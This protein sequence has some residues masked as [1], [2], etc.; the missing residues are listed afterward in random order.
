MQVTT[1]RAVLD[2]LTLSLGLFLIIFF[3]ILPSSFFH[4][5]F[6]AADFN[7]AK[8]ITA[9]RSISGANFFLFITYLANWQV[10]LTSQVCIIIALIATRRRK[11]GMVFAGGVFLGLLTAIILKL[12][13]GRARPEGGFLPFTGTDSFP[14]YHALMAVIFYGLAGY[15]LAHSSKK[16]LS[17][18]IILTFTSIL[19]FLIGFSRLYLG[20]HWLSDVI[21]GWALGSALL[22]LFIFIFERLLHLNHQSEKPISLNFIHALY[23]FL[24]VAETFF[25]TYFY[26]SHPL[27]GALK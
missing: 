5:A 26:I 2:I 27:S 7:F 19:V 13:V 9:H 15:L 25:I 11:E 12:I 20:V 16:S 4:S 17:R 10:I 21:A 1:K 8:Y 18:G 24:L 23:I 6:Y 14:S 3:S 22:M